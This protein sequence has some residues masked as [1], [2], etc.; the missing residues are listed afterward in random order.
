MSNSESRERETTGD[1]SSM[2]VTSAGLNDRTGP[3]SPHRSLYLSP[4]SDPVSV[5]RSNGVEH[6][7]LD[8]SFT[9]VLSE[10]C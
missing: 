9:A 7:T 2:S 5:M 3:N 1:N 4:C 6:V 8:D 10:V